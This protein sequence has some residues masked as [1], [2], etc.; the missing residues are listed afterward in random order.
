MRV[1]WSA[2]GSGS[3]E[4]FSWFLALRLLLRK[5]SVLSRGFFYVSTRTGAHTLHEKVRCGAWVP[6]PA[7]KIEKNV[8]QNVHQGPVLGE[9]NP[10]SEIQ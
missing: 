8:G 9:H 1:R 2:I 5:R 4:T 3:P 10:W 6:S 7:I